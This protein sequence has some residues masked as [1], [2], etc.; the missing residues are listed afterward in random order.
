MSDYSVRDYFA[1]VDYAMVIDWWEAHD[2]PVVPAHLLAPCGFIAGRNGADMA[3]LWI[4]F[5][6]SV[7]VCFAECA[8]T[9]PGLGVAEAAGALLTL[10]DTAK[11]FARNLGYAV[12]KLHTPRGMARFLEH[13]AGFV[14]DQRE[15]V[16]MSCTLLEEEAWEL[17]LP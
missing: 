14:A 2:R 13:R 5:D 17:N 15:M 9:A 16:S 7:H 8:V 3:A 12:M 10:I 4:Y 1:P 11:E 6:G